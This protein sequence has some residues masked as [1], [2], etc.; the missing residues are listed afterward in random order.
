M[1]ANGDNVAYFDSSGVEHI[2]KEITK[3]IGNKNIWTNIFRIKAYDSIMWGYFYNEFID[4]T[5]KGRSLLD[6][7]N[8][9]CRNEN[10]KNDK[11]IL[12]HSQ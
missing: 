9:F 2:P 3:L 5:L 4:F 10:E 8:L 11:I 12:K 6:W 7:T 1:Y